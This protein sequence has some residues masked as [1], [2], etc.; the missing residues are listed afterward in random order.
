[1]GVKGQRNG[2]VQQFMG[3]FYYKSKGT[4][5]IQS[6]WM[7]RRSQNLDLQPLKQRLNCTALTSP[8]ISN[9]WDDFKIT[10]EHLTVQN[11]DNIRKGGNREKAG[12][13]KIQR[14]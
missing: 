1:M 3:H 9:R 12:T 10:A 6:S 4:Q 8:A 14:H 5:A 2:F 7:R 11:L 13:T